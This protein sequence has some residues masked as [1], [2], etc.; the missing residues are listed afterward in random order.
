MTQ[1]YIDGKEAVIKQGTSF[2]ITRENPFTE[3]AGDSTLD[4]TLPLKGCAENIKIFGSLHRADMSKGELPGKRYPFV[5]NTGVFTIEGTAV[6]NT[7]T[8]SEVKMQLL[9]GRSALNLE[10]KDKDGNDVFVDELKLGRAYEEFW[11]EYK[12]IYEYR[13]ISEELL[14]ALSLS[15]SEDIRTFMHSMHPEEYIIPYPFRRLYPHEVMFP[16]YSEPDGG[17][18]NPRA[19]QGF[20]HNSETYFYFDYPVRGNLQ[21]PLHTDNGTI[22]FG[23][24]PI[25]PQP[26]LWYI[27]ERVLIKAFG[28]SYYKRENNCIYND[29]TKNQIF[30]ANCRAT[31]YY[32]QMLPHWTVKEFLTE[33][34]NFL[35][36]VFTMEGGSIYV[37]SRKEHYTG[38]D[39]AYTEIED[40]VDEFSTE[41][42]DEEGS[43]DMAVCN[44]GYAMED[45]P[46]AIYIPE[47]IWDYARFEAYEDM[48]EFGGKFSQMT[49][50][51][52]AEYKDYIFY[53]KDDGRYFIIDPDFV[54]GERGHAWRPANIAG[55]LLRHTDKP[56]ETDITLKIV[57]CRMERK[58]FPIYTYGPNSDGLWIR[59]ETGMYFSQPCLVTADSRTCNTYDRVSI[60]DLI[61]GSEEIQEPTAKRDIIEV[62]INSWP[63]NRWEWLTGKDIYDRGVWAN[64]E[65]RGDFSTPDALSAEVVEGYCQNIYPTERDRERFELHNRGENSIMADAL[66][67]GFEIDTRV[68]HCFKFADKICPD[69]KGVF[70]IR[71]KRYV[72]QKIEYTIDERGVAPIKTGYF[73]EMT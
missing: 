23:T 35:G 1:L 19:A 16:I 8:E 31:L 66:A 49:P 20:H 65:V 34:S 60:L 48:N 13:E 38:D 46:K 9:G 24:D 61:N 56:K 69:V 17:F 57:P 4:V 32:D 29:T 7:V 5:L 73:Y 50:E 2:K 36:V 70:L 40:I 33:V 67:P 71:G 64:A 54:P 72:C 39:A 22:S 21:Q 25:A 59:T 6:V 47:E 12:Y 14:I 62:G 52:R 42:E 10:C 41:I 37:R 11:E 55:N 18:S 30:I 68:K 63:Y 27:V 3:D 53:I 44:V 43:K 51:E 58:D 26:Y 15:R 45:A 28:A